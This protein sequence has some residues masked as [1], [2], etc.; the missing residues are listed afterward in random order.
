MIV[1]AALGMWKAR[2]CYKFVAGLDYRRTLWPEWA[3]QTN[4]T[5]ML[6]EKAACLIVEGKTAN[7]RT[8]RNM[9]GLFGH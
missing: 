9:T 2:G 4:L 8:Y 3:K 6:I 7:M 5:R 1:T